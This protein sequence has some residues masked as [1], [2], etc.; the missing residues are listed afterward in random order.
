MNTSSTNINIR[1]KLVLH[2]YVSGMSVK[3]METIENIKRIC[4]QYLKDSFELEIT[5]IYKNPKAAAEYQIVFS[6]CLI[7]KFPLPRKLLVGTLSD[8]DKVLTAL[9]VSFKN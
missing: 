8:T 3:S 1:E 6:P 4:D 2:L 5:D 9:G 7:K